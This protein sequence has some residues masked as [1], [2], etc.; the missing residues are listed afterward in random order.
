MS[1]APFDLADVGRIA[2]LNDPEGAVFSGPPAPI[3]AARAI[4]ERGRRRTSESSVGGGETSWMA[5]GSPRST[6]ARL[7]RVFTMR[8]D[9]PSLV[10][11]VVAQMTLSTKSRMTCASSWAGPGDER[12]A[13]RYLDQPSLRKE[14]GEAATV[15]GRHDAVFAGPD[16]EGGAVV[17]RQALG[18]VEHEVLVCRDRAGLGRCRGGSRAAAGSA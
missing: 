13:V 15:V 16:D 5:I 7:S 10:L 11:R 4:Q 2:V 3:T 14:L 8:N 9:E 18:G 17:A 1:V 12:V 6:L